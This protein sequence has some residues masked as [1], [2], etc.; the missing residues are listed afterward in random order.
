M[1]AFAV[2]LLFLERLDEVTRI[3]RLIGCLELM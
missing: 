2:L 3:V 1:V